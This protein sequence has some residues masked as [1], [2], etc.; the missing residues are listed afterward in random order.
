MFRTAA[1]RYEEPVC[2][3]IRIKYFLRYT[4]NPINSFR[5]L[6]NVIIQG[7]PF[8]KGLRLFLYRGCIL[9]TGNKKNREQ[10]FLPGKNGSQSPPCWSR[11]P[12]YNSHECQAS[13]TRA[14]P[15]PCAPAESPRQGSAEVPLCR[16]CRTGAAHWSDGTARGW[17]PGG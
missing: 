2:L 14:E 4:T 8:I 17:K 7:V 16:L 10:E 11:P 5:E 3:Y 15:A 12:S 9:P 13:P 6:W 1:P